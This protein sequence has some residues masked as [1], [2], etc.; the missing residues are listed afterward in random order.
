MTDS[1]ASGHSESFGRS[2]PAN[3][4]PISSQLPSFKD[5]QELNLW[6]RY[7]QTGCYSLRII[8]Y[9]VIDF[10]QHSSAKPG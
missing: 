7:K 8:Q 6:K 4:L 9:Q 5:S 1:V 2:P 3:Y 10:P